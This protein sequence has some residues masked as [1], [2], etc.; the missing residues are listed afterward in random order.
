MSTNYTLWLQPLLFPDLST[1]QCWMATLMKVGVA[2]PLVFVCHMKQDSLPLF[3]QHFSIAITCCKHHHM[4]FETVRIHGRRSSQPVTLAFLESFLSP[5]LTNAKHHIGGRFHH[6]PFSWNLG[7]KYGSL[8][9]LLMVTSSLARSRMHLSNPSFSIT[10]DKVT[11]VT[12]TTL[13]AATFPYL[14]S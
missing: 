2:I 5:S 13:S 12:C 4:W 1:G 3:F 8:A 9:I 11:S 14:S 10:L 6:G 7:W